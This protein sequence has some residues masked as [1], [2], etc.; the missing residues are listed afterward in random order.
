MSEQCHGKN[1]ESSHV[2][3]VFPPELIEVCIDEDGEFKFSVGSVVSTDSSDEY[4]QDKEQLNTRLSALLA[5]YHIAPEQWVDHLIAR[6]GAHTRAVSGRRIK[7]GGE[8]RPIGAF[9]HDETFRDMPMEW[10]E[11]DGGSKV[12]LKIEL[13]EQ[14]I[15]EV[16]GRGVYGRARFYKNPETGET[17]TLPTVDQGFDAN[18]DVDDPSYLGYM[19]WHRITFSGII[20]AAEAR[21]Q[22]AD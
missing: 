21:E 8:Q 2:K 6:E 13:S 11:L 10:G 17:P 14:H 7:A 1:L 3:P 4:T 16:A 20:T 15:L 19:D 18:E 22:I 12:V 5:Q 9:L